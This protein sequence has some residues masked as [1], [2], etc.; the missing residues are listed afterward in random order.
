MG[1][2]KRIT[3]GGVLGASCAVTS[4]CL[5]ENKAALL[6]IMI[7]DLKIQ[8]KILAKGGQLETSTVSKAWL[9]AGGWLDRA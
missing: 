3:G 5:K 7:T 9:G 6:Q 1:W 8:G 2:G 4:V